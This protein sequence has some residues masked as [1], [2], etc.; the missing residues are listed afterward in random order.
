MPGGIILPA[1]FYIK[2]RCRLQSAP[3]FLSLRGKSLQLPA[4]SLRLRRGK[5]IQLCRHKT[6]IESYF[7]TPK[8]F[9][10]T[11]TMKTGITT[12]IRVLSNLLRGLAFL[13]SCLWISLV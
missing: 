10:R 6:S 5:V 9:I 7:R 8:T 12:V 11:M 3:G 13:G 4:G 1:I 2:T